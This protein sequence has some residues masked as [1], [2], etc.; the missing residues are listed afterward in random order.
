MCDHVIRIIKNTKCRSLLDLNYKDL[1]VK[2]VCQNNNN[3]NNDHIVKFEK[4]GG[5]L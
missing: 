3:N 4:L 1:K 5:C 2:G